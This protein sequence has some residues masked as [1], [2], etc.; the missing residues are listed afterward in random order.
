MQELDK[1]F[2]LQ[3]GKLA[4][5]FAGCSA[6]YWQDFNSAKYHPEVTDL[7]EISIPSSLNKAVPKRLAEKESFYKAVFPFE[8]NFFKFFIKKLVLRLKAYFLVPQIESINY[9]ISY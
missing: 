1:G 5:P 3:A 4:S 6:I 9:F 7:L 8:Q 2:I